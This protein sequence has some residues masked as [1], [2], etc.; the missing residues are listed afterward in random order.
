M[1]NIQ[2]LGKTSDS[3]ETSSIQVETEE[4]KAGSSKKVLRGDANKVVVSG[5]GLK[6]GHISRIG[7][8]NVEFKEAGGWQI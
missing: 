5:A 4:K 8:F 1:K 7:N 3:H 2:G 6:K